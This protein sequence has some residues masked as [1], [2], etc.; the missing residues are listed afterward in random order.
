MTEKVAVVSDIH[1]NIHAL[2]AV[3]A[4]IHNAGVDLI[5]NLGDSLYGPLWPLETARRI[6][7]E[8]MISIAG[9]EDRLILEAK[10]GPAHNQTIQ[11]N[12][13]AL[14]SACLEWLLTLAPMLVQG[15]IF[16]CHGTMADDCAY[17][18][19]TIAQSG[20]E[21]KSPEV[22]AEIVEKLPQDIILCGHSHVPRNIPLGNGKTI[23]NPGSVGLPA[24]TD[25]LPRPHK[26]E[27]GRPDAAFAVLTLVK[28]RLLG[29]E[30]LWVPYDHN[31]A[32]RQAERNNRSDWARWLATGRA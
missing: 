29:V 10:S 24:Y 11:E 21:I 27:T 13:E 30:H 23:I 2:E 17:L 31:A 26:M 20:V 18:C 4:K 22:L 15:D 19:E 8:N 16:L 12:L 28:G 3:L 5:L 9:N 14:D 25:D 1:G 32:A 7:Q 6:R